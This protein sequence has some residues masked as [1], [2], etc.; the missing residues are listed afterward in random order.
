M[1][2][3]REVQLGELLRCQSGFAFKSRDWTTAGVPVVKIRDVRSGVVRLDGASFVASDTAAA[4]ERFLLRRG[5]VLITMSGEI[6][7]VGVYKHDRPALLNQRVGR[8]QL[9]NSSAADL[10]FLTFALQDPTQKQ[11]FESVAYGVAQP[12]ISPS[13]IGRARVRIPSLATQRRIAA[14]LSAFDEL[15]EVNERRIEL[16][17]D[18]ARSLYREWFA[19]FRFPGHEDVELVDSELGPIPEGWKVRSL[20]EL[21]SLL[22]SGGTP[23]RS[24][25]S[26][27]EGGITPWFKTGELRDGPLFDSAEHVTAQSHARTFD[28]PAV[29]MAIYGSPTVGRLGWVTRPSSCNQA[30]LA[31]RTANPEL[32]QD[33]LWY[34]LESQ[35]DR[36]NAM[37][38]GAA[39][40]NISKQKVVET[41]VGVPTAGLLDQFAVRV[42]P[43]RALW[44]ELAA[45]NRQL[46]ATRD[47]LLPRLVTGRLDISDIDLG[48][49]TPAEV[50]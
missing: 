47:R 20:G 17:E 19:H 11:Y 38:Q 16:L 32:E 18:L 2:E 10:N 35:R 8:F 43:M 3:W 13:L 25:P 40:Q 27:W 9:L 48:V 21:C 42:R 1:N 30:A 37:A 39:Q 45:S 28:P 6:G 15:I 50:D 7:S 49:L 34:A 44:Q 31:M 36:F 29:L 33:W 12:N 22:R 14:V 4:A 46:A 26:N 41:R 24:N 5:D 23:K